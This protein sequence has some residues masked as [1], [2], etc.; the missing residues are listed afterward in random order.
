MAGSL[1]SEAC[2]LTEGGEG[3]ELRHA[4]G[5]VPRRQVQDAKGGGDLHIRSTVSGA[6]L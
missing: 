1:A 4:A 2:R 3:V 5:L 6:M